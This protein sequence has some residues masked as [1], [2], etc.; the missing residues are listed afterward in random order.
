MNFNGLM[1]CVAVVFAGFSGPI[2]A[3]SGKKSA[4]GGVVID[5]PECGAVS[6]TNGEMVCNCSRVNVGGSVWG[7]GPYTADS[8]ICTAALHAGAIDRDGGIVRLFDRPGQSSYD[9]S[10]ANGVTTGGWGSYGQSFDVAAADGRA[11]DRVSTLPVCATLPAGVDSY[12]CSCAA[13]AA[14]GSVWGNGPYTAD[15]D[16]CTAAR[17]AGYIDAAGGD[18]FVLRAQGLAGYS[19]GESNGITTSDWGAYGDSIVFNWNR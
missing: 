10:S 1:L 12:D 7:S 6:F 11:P 15:S 2:L 3:Q 18:V 14:G 9:G 19:G 5:A 4:S 13:G 8:D 17:H 16:I